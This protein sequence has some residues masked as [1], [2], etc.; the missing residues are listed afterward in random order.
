MIPLNVANLAEESQRRQKELAIEDMKRKMSYGVL[1][2]VKF[3][4]SG[5]GTSDRA[6]MMEISFGPA[7]MTIYGEMVEE[8]WTKQLLVG[9]SGKQLLKEVKKL[10]PDN[11]PSAISAYN[12]I[13]RSIESELKDPETSWRGKWRLRIDPKPDQTD[14]YERP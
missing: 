14:I 12:H 5:G 8:F 4:M 10:F 6:P 1:P 2:D 11:V 7:D 13:V 3:Q 9:I